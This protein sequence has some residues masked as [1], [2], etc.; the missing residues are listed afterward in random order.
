MITQ[1]SKVKWRNI[2]PW[3]TK[4][5]IHFRQKKHIMYERLRGLLCFKNL[6]THQIKYVICIKHGCF[7]AIIRH[8]D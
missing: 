7:C 4:D 1:R 6:Q 2:M 8:N 5:Y 3:I